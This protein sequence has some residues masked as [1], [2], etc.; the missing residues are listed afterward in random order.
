M[1]STAIFI[2]VTFAGFEC[3]INFLVHKS[4]DYIWGVWT[5]IL[6]GNIDSDVIVMGSSRA[7]FQYNPLILDSILGCNAYNIGIDGSSANRQ[8]HRYNIYRKKNKKPK[9]IVQNID[10]W[11]TLG[12]TIGYSREQFLPFVHKP[13]MKEILEDEPLSWYDKIPVLRYKG[14]SNA[15]SICINILVGERT[16]ETVQ[17]G[18]KGNDWPWNGAMLNKMDSITF[19]PDERSLKMFVDYVAQAKQEDIEMV[20]V[21][22]PFYYEGLNLYTNLD[23][24]Y[25]LFD[26]IATVY[27]VPILDYSYSNL[28]YDKSYFY[29]ATHL[30]K[31]GAELFSAQLAHDLDSL[32][33]YSREEIHE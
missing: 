16:G 33:I 8:I 25:A 27:S 20:F 6:D 14:F 22:A 24:C 32:G 7:V 17:K 31:V 19:K 9:V 2:A 13:E 11:S 5:D 28:S 10:A 4:N 23:E 30:K 15:I 18:Y 29:N 26:S 21:Y 3:V 12:F 1:I